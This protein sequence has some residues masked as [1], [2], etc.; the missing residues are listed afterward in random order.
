M[1][2]KK[3]EMAEESEFVNRC[4]Q[5]KSRSERGIDVGDGCE[6]RGRGAEIV[7]EGEEVGI[8]GCYGGMCSAMT[9]LLLLK[10]LNNVS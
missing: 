1:V 3:T 4:V 5:V 8:D 10:M 7:E 9:E 6:R 2:V